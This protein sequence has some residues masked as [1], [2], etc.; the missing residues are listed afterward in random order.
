MILEGKQE[1]ALS[2]ERLF[3][4]LHN[5]EILRKCT[6]GCQAVTVVA[7]NELEMA[8]KVGIAVVSG[9]YKGK[10]KMTDNL[11]PESYKMQVSGT[12]PI[13]IMT[14]NGDIRLD[15]N[16]EGSV[17]QYSFEVK[18]GGAMAN[19]GL[20]ALNPIAKMLMK[21]FFNNVGREALIG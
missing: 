6:P 3:D 9:S 13:G 1:F 10:M 7:E 12:G 20:R 19:L 21:E 16:G 8:L 15:E 17:M 14:V 2:R 4:A 5:P 18:I 11:R